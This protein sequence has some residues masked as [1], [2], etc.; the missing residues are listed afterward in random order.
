MIQSQ[1]FKRDQDAQLRSLEFS[2]R[3]SDSVS[4]NDY[5]LLQFAQNNGGL[6][7]FNLI[8]GPDRAANDWNAILGGGTGE[9]VDEGDLGNADD[10]QV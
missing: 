9:D 4:R 1:Y 2:V 7:L 8:W 10:W 3:Y 5:E 6:K